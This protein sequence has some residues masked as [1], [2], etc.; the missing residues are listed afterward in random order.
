MDTHSKDPSFF[1]TLKKENYKCP[2]KPQFHPP[3]LLLVFGSSASV[4]WYMFHKLIAKRGAR[5]GAFLPYRLMHV[6]SQQI[7]DFIVVHI[8]CIFSNPSSAFWGGRR[9]DAD[10]ILRCRENSGSSLWQHLQP[11]T[12][13]VSPYVCTKMIKTTFY[14]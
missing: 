4:L 13:D 6:S 9:T 12:L 14:F 7:I 5:R 10:N 2:W 11:K 3:T 1:N 8:L